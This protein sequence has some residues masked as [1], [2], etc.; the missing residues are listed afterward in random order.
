MRRRGDVARPDPG[1]VINDE[2]TFQLG[3][4]P[5]WAEFLRIEVA[6]GQGVT[7]YGH[8][9]L[10]RDR[11]PPDERTIQVDLEITLSAER[12]PG[13]LPSPSG[14]RI[15]TTGTS[16]GLQVWWDELDGDM[17]IQLRDRDGLLASMRR[18]LKI[19]TMDIP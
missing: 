1:I 9:V 7:V 8:L 12:R 16:R 10:T 3:D 11:S 5:T 17:V 2:I 18:D 6:E 13:E 19:T 4:A 14:N 15:T